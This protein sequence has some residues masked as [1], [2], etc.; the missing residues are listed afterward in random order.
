MRGKPAVPCCLSFSIGVAIGRYLLEGHVSFQAAFLAL[1]IFLLVGAVVAAL[2]GQRSPFITFLALVGMTF[3]GALRYLMATGVTGDPR[4]IVHYAEQE[5]PV[6]LQGVAISWPDQRPGRALVTLRVGQLVLPHQTASVRGKALLS[7]RTDR[8]PIRYGD[9]LHVEGFLRLPRDQ[10]NPGEFDYREYLRARGVYAVISCRSMECVHYVEG[11]HGSWL[12]GKVVYPLRRRITCTID[13]S[14]RGE[15]AAFLKGLLVGERGEIPAE[16]RQAFA[17]TGVV[18]VLAVSG[19]HV[20]FV[21]LIA[22]SLWSVLRMPSGVRFAFT[23]V[24]LVLFVLLT[25]ARPPV[26]RA[27]IMAAVLLGST[28]LRRRS[29]VYNSLGVAGLVVLLINPLELF[30]AGCQLSFAA[31][32]SIVSLYRGVQNSI[33]RVWMRAVERDS[34]LGTSVLPLLCV[35][36]AA[37]LGTLP[38]TAYYFGRVPIISLVA[39][40]LVVPTVGVIVAFGYTTVL[41]SL[42]SWSVAKLYAASNWLLLTA[43]IRGVAWLGDLPFSSVAYVRPRLLHAVAYYGLLACVF[44]LRERHWRLRTLVFILLLATTAL[45]ADAFRPRATL[46]A[47]V[48]DVGQ[49]DA[50]FLR[51][52][53]GRCLLVDAGPADSSYDAGR[54]VIE[55]FLRYRGVRRLDGLV[56]THPHNDHCGG[57]THLLRSLPVGAILA[58]GQA[59]AEPFYLTLRRVA[60]SLKVP[61]RVVQAGE[62]L[63]GWEP[64]ALFVLHPSPEFVRA[65]GAPPYGLNNSSVVLLAVYGRTRL[66]LTADA[67][68]AAEQAM[69]RFGPLLRSQVLK[70]AHHGSRTSSGEAFLAEVAPEVAVLSVGA[71][72]PHGLPSA[73]VLARLARQG[74]LIWRTDRQGAAVLRSNGQQW[75]LVQWKRRVPDLWELLS[76]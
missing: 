61:W 26:V 64:A 41:V 35:S 12:L 27:S 52:A 51:F 63:S 73:E 2:L 69:L 50:I 71:W 45:W 44:H 1:G 54:Q 58:S 10:R 7:L 21:L 46:E 14:L 62:E 76:W 9:S 40:L 57:A 42:L 67:E 55:P 30:Q 70:V 8:C 11:G 34:F 33:T 13:R 28:A 68:G 20:G 22:G 47:T 16:L 6:V 31:V 36:L 74:A 65:G 18:H 53:N 3:A 60:D 56:V 4:H 15:Q 48:L 49:G 19:L 5:G 75:H 66:L 32:A 17:T 25:E 39:N 29:N 23:C 37:Q 43:L 38:L 72:N 24:V 59:A